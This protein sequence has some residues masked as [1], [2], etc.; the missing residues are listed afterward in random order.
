MGN[1]QCIYSGIKMCSHVGAIGKC[2][3]ILSSGFILKLEKTF[4]IPCFSR[5]FI[6]ISRLV[7]F[8]Y[9]FHFPETSFML[10]YKFDL[11]GNGKLSGGLFSISLQNNTTYKLCMFKLVLNDVL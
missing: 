7:A 6:S 8:D 10:F 2:G 11:V 9:S 1:A 3:V 5:N 4:Y